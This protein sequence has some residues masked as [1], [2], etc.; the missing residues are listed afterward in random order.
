MRDTHQ[1]GHGIRVACLG[2]IE[3]RAAPT[4]LAGFR[5]GFP[6]LTGWADL[7]RAYGAEK[8]VA[9]APCTGNYYAKQKGHAVSCPYNG[10]DATKIGPEIVVPPLLLRV[11]GYGP[12]AQQ[13][14]P[15]QGRT[16]EAAPVGWTASPC[17]FTPKNTVWGT[18]S[19][20][21]LN[22]RA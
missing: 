5:F 13:A 14:A 19:P 20:E 2:A 3:G 10:T 7:W 8:K 1:G 18:G 17:Q 22:C 11:P 6:T 16:G 21:T 15:L 12:E 4:A 9:G